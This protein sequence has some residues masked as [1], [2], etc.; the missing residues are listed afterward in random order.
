VSYEPKAKAIHCG[1]ETRLIA[2]HVL[3]DEEAETA[4]DQAFK[5][6]FGD[7]ARKDGSIHR[8]AFLASQYAGEKRLE[9][10]GQLELFRQTQKLPDYRRAEDAVRRGWAHF[11]ALEFRMGAESA[12]DKLKIRQYLLLD[13]IRRTPSGE[14]RRRVLGRFSKV[15]LASF[16]VGD[17]GFLRMLGRTLDDPPRK[18]HDNYD[19]AQVLLRYWLTGFWW[20]MPLQAVAADMARIQGDPENV[21]LIG[22]FSYRLRQIVSRR[23]KGA[24]GASYS[25]GWNGCFYSSRPPLIGSIENDGR[26]VFTDVG[27]RLL[28]L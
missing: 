1:D 12:G 7:R 24:P 23:S 18:K 20:L 25:S 22:R 13:T 19:T 11:M 15:G 10:L 21:Q 28:K 27:R 9:K 14:A 3:S 5:E 4:F 6:E 17:V 16:L 8:C 26:H 2:D